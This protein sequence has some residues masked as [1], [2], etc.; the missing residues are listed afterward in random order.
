MRKGQR[1]KRKIAALFGGCVP[2]YNRSPRFV[3][4]EI[5]ESSC[6]AEDVVVDGTTSL[7]DGYYRIG[8]RLYCVRGGMFLRGDAGQTYTDGVWTFDENG[9]YTTG[10]TELDQRLNAIVEKYTNSSMT[11]D[12]KLRALF[13]YLRDH[14]TYMDL[15]HITKGQTDWEADYALP[16]LQSG[17]GGCFSFSAAYCLLCRELGQPAYTVVGLLGRKREAHGWVEIVL[18]GTRYMFDPQLEWRFLHDYG[19]P[20]YDLFKMIPGQT[21]FTYIW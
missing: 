10:N 3:P 20:G 14:Y 5:C 9:R 21:P 13:V 11:R 1:I 8:G 2:K 7:A 16:F 19:Q 4:E 18:D 12:E 15:P 6:E 17:K